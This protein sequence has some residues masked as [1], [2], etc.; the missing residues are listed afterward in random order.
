MDEL[1]GVDDLVERAELAIVRDD[2]KEVGV[3]VVKAGNLLGIEG[4]H[5]LPE[6]GVERQEIKGGHLD[7]R[8][9]GLWRGHV[10]FKLA[11][12]VGLQLR[13]GKEGAGDRALG[14]EAA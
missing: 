3:G 14:F 5:E 8:K 10:L 11:D 13:P 4:D 1:V 7:H 9:A 12:E 6:V 2:H